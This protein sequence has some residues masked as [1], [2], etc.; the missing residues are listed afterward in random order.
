MWLFAFGPK[1]TF[2]GIQA[3]Y[4]S[5]YAWLIKLPGLDT[6]RTPA[7]F[8]MAAMLCLSTAASLCFARIVTLLPRSRRIVFTAAI[9]IVALADTWIWGFPME[10]APKP[11]PIQQQE[12]PGPVLE[13]PLGSSVGNDV[14]AMYRSMWTGNPVVNGY[15]GFGPPWYGPVQMG[16]RMHDRALLEE[17]SSR[18][19][20]QLLVNTNADQSEGWLQY[21]A[22][23]PDIEFVGTDGAH[24]LYRLPPAPPVVD[25][26]F[27]PPVRIAGITANVN[28]S[29][30]PAMTDG[31]LTTRWETG[32][33]R[34][35]EACTID[36]GGPTRVAAIVLA[37][38]EFPMDAP[39][40]LSIEVSD[41]GQAWTEVWHAGGAGRAF[42]AAFSDPVRIPATF[43][44]GD[45][46][47]RFIRMRQL[48]KD[49]TYYWSVA[50]LSVLGPA[51]R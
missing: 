34:G 29:Q 36:L 39:R 2:M 37:Q 40:D 14:E 4:T 31:D 32:P 47:T 46:T 5:P 43:D 27:G 13:L 7:R 17:L 21:L 38:G 8:H 33:Q 41:D 42:R 18:G 20:R 49:E 19:I 51:A 28:G 30:I 44:I 6:L 45:R 25:R 23:R 1:P 26:H 35:L 24:R 50:E 48:G 15:S 11:W 22:T 16:L 3:L 10:P 12:S 9:A